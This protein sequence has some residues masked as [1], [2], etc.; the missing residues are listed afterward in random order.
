MKNNG[1]ITA[2]TKTV[3]GLMSKTEKSKGFADRAVNSI[4]TLQRNASGILADQ[5]RGR[6]EKMFLMNELLQKHKATLTQI[7]YEWL[8]SV[9][10]SIAKAERSLQAK[11]NGGDE[12][13]SLLLANHMNEA[14]T[15]KPSSYST[16]AK[17][18]PSYLQAL[19]SLPADYFGLEKDT[20]EGIIRSAAR[21]HFPDE[22]AAI[23]EAAEHFSSYENFQSVMNSRV[24]EI[25]SQIETAGLETR[26]TPEG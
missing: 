24:S 21:E 5:T 4:E 25:E 9:E 20:H 2:L 17:A 22:T 18:H 15:K 3:K 23:D 12:V 8:T 7:D 13:K 16:L 6:G 1:K 26:F 14:A 10:T 19:N 11:L